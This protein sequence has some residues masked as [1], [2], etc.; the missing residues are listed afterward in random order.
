[1]NYSDLDTDTQSIIDAMCTKTGWSKE[2]AILAFVEFGMLSM[3]AAIQ[4]QCRDMIMDRVYKAVNADKN[5]V[6]TAEVYTAV[7][8]L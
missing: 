4:P 7:W 8:S 3:Q 6:V 5:L 2:K 1:M